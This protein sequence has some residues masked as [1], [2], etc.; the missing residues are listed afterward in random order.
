MKIGI[1]GSNGFIGNNLNLYLSDKKK[2]KIFCFS[3][4]NKYKVDW[5]EKI[6]SEIKKHKPDVIINCAANQNSKDDKKA[7]IDLLNS[8]LK[9]NILFMKQAIKNKNFKGYISFG[10]KWEFNENGKFDPLNFYAATKHAN[11][12]FF[13]YFSSKNNI[14]TVS[15]KIFETYGKFDNRKRVLN[16]LL[17]NYKEQKILNVSP[18]NQFLDYVHI[19][20]ICELIELICDDILKNKLKGF[21]VYAVSSKK[22]IKLKSLIKKINKNLNKKIKVIIGGKKY[23]INEAMKPIR[24]IDNYPGWK[25]KLNLI[26]ELKKIFDEQK[27]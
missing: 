4:F 8:N 2:F 15:L 26:K 14:T 3:S 1:I 17:K 27:K 12:I 22:P 7:I 11:D 25:P 21:N 5:I 13:K 16:L 19:S 18:G 10:T 6:S 20:E 9:A 23:R 24:G